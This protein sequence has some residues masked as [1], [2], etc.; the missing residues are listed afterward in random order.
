MESGPIVFCLVSCVQLFM[1]PRTVTH[2]APLSM[3][4]L[5]ERILKWVALPS[6]RGSSQSRDWTQ[7]SRIASGFFTV[8]ATREAH[9]CWTGSSI[10]SPG[11]LSNPGIEP[12]SHALQADSLPAVL[13]GKPIRAHYFIGNRRERVGSSDSSWTLKSLQMVTADMKSEDDRSLA[14]KPWQTVCWKAETSLCQQRFCWKFSFSS[15][16]QRIC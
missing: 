9:E 8:W 3:G 2:Q 10:P 4:I 14:G 12:E 11:D 6:S 16:V 15:Q 1:T 5:Q 7:I 13:P